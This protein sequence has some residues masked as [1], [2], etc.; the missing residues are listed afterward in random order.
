MFVINYSQDS[1][2]SLF[3]QLLTSE[4]IST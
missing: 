1:V 4:V 3:E 2:N